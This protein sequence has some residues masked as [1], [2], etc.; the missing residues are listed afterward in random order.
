MMQELLTDKKLDE[1]RQG[2]AFSPVTLDQNRSARRFYIESYGCQMNFSVSEIVA[3]I[4]TIDVSATPTFEEADL[5]LFQY[6]SHTYA[7]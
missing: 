7:K 5:I 2:E 1:K 3:S 6:C 4:L